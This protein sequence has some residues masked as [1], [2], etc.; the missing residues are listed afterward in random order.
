MQKPMFS[1]GK[2]LAGLLLG[3][4]LALAGCAANGSLSSEMAAMQGSPQG[5]ATATWGTP[6]VTEAFADGTLLIWLDY[7]GTYSGAGTPVVI[8]E[9]Q[10]SVDATG[11]ISGWRW[12]GDACESL[13]RDRTTTAAMQAQ[14]R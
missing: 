9:R 12:R 3:W 10:I 2:I 7:A 5:H 11:S 8:C 1:N 14:R 6:T 4:T 13:H